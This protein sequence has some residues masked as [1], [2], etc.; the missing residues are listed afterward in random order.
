MLLIVLNH[1]IE[2]GTNMPRSYGIPPVEGT[3]RIALSLLQALGV[4]AVP[5]FLFISGTFVC[6]AARG[7]PPRLTSRF[8]IGSLGHILW[9]YLLWSG[10]FYLVVFLQSG[11]SYTLRGYV[12]N[13]LVGYPFHFIPLL[14]LFYL[15]SPLLVRIGRRRG[16][17]LIAVLAAYQI[18]LL[19]LLHTSLLPGWMKVLVPPALGRVLS[20]WA[21][22][23]PLGLVYGLHMKA[24]LPR[25]RR[26]RWLLAAAAVVAFILGFLHF[27]RVVDLP[28]AG[29]LAQPAFV[30]LLPVFDRGSIP[31]VGR[32]EA[33]GKR[34]Y[35]LYL[36]HLLVLDLALWGIGA[37]MPALF[38][39]RLSLLPFL[40]AIGLCLPLLAM[41]ALARSP[42][43]A[44]YRY[45]FG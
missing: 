28:L 17:T 10:V 9:P 22:Y 42:A 25:L 45:L 36:T 21:V 23:F 7:E 31:L 40:L 16:S 37:F 14:M 44:I 18:L 4:F 30:M 38:T 5:V 2:M 20:D 3:A 35:G 41:S 8:L 19:A 13:L 1:T 26:A 11:E 39:W 24:M 34:S 15:L 12:K 29:Y 33:I 27:N 6:Y 32:L 43:R